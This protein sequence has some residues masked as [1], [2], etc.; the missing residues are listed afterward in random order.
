MSSDT[1]ALREL[2]AAATPGEW[3]V[4]LDGGGHYAGN[5]P[6]SCFENWE[7]YAKTPERP[8]IPSSE[9]D[10]DL[11]VAL[12]TTAPALLDEIDRLRE[13]ERAA[14]EATDCFRCGTYDEGC[15]VCRDSRTPAVADA[16]RKL[17][18]LRASSPSGGGR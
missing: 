2:L 17:D 15:A 9:A 11:I 5:I 18:A 13:V 10:A 12:H 14:R 6:A 7:V 8:R 16:L 4:S 1:K 3:N